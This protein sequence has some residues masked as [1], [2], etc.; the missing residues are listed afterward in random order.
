MKPVSEVRRAN[1]EVLL[2]THSQ[3]EVAKAAGGKTSPVYINQLRKQ[4]LDRSTGRPRAIRPRAP[5][6]P[7]RLA[8]KSGRPPY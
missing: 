2:R 1:L 7:Q 8:P 5:D 6:P 3:V 4:T